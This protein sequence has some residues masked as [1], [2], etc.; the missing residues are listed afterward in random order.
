MCH[1]G[2]R[3]LKLSE[4]DSE[5][6]GLV[7]WKN[8][9]VSSVQTGGREITDRD[10]KLGDSSNSPQERIVLKWENERTNGMETCKRGRKGTQNHFNAGSVLIA[11]L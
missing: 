8:N 5:V 6:L 11:V 10:D 9:E 2:H 1:T 4:Q 7:L 3:E